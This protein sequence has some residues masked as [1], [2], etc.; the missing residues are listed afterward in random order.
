MQ[1]TG[2]AW[3]PMYEAQ[4]PSST[5]VFVLYLALVLL[6]S[7]FRAISLVRQLWWLQKAHVEGSTQLT[8][9]DQRASPTSEEAEIRFHLVLEF[10]HAKIASMKR[11]SVLTFLL[12][13]LVLAWGTAN[14][15]HGVAMGK[16]TGSAFLAGAMAEGLTSFSLG[17]FVC[18]V[19]YAFVTFYE[20]VLARRKMNFDH[21][22]NKHQ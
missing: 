6:V 21:A 5:K 9:A 3:E 18:A 2:V 7:A 22:R 20:G 8:T 16:V 12:T 10:C 1:K 11:L 14:I 15:L 13:L 4:L 19:I 17:I